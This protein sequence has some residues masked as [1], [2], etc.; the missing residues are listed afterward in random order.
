MRRPVV[1]RALRSSFLADLGQM[2]STDCTWPRRHAARPR[3][4]RCFACQMITVEEMG[5]AR[6]PGGLH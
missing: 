6:A 5:A 1:P 2:R 3:C 4:G